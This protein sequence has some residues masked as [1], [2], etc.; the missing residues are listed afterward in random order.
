MK[1][2]IISIIAAAFAVIAGV[3]GCSD[4]G[5]NSVP[6]EL[7][8]TW[9]YQSATLDG[10]P[11]DWFLYY[12]GEFGDTASYT[13]NDDRTWNR[14]VYGETLDTIQIGEGTYIVKG[15]SLTT[16]MTTLDGD[17]LI[18]PVVM[19]YMFTVTDSLLAIT[20]S[21]ETG[22]GITEVYIITY[23]KE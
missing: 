19:G 9:W 23:L 6:S 15:D 13:F 14:I 11:Y 1:K 8:G 17:S 5:T 2:A 21:S 3:S 18:D 20:L 10:V 7:L 16:T 22:G 4:S 12:N